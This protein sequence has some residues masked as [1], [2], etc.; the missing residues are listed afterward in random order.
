M[1]YEPTSWRKL[2]SAIF[3][4]SHGFSSTDDIARE[5]SKKFDVFDD[6]TYTQAVPAQEGGNSSNDT[7]SAVHSSAPTTASAAA[8]QSDS[9]AAGSAF[10]AS[11]VASSATRDEEKAPQRALPGA[12]LEIISQSMVVWAELAPSQHSMRHEHYGSQDATSGRDSAQHANGPDK[13]SNGSSINP[14]ADSQV[15]R[16]VK[17]AAVHKMQVTESNSRERAR[18]S[19]QDLNTAMVWNPVAWGTPQGIDDASKEPASVAAAFLLA[20]HSTGA[21][22]L[23]N[24]LATRL[25]PISSIALPD[26]VQSARDILARRNLQSTVR[27][28]AINA[29]A[30]CS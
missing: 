25:V 5:V 28:H 21:S 10:D 12:A 20:T 2:T 16:L 26:H 18:L 8:S 11:G 1:Q 24:H 9:A 14:T 17:A 7:H 15:A 27:R 29:L 30:C 23:L 3:V 22:T 13:S 19:I 4:L 6:R